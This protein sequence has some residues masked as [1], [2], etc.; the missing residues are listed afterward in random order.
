MLTA[1]E[2]PSTQ[3]AGGVNLPKEWSG[4]IWFLV[5]MGVWVFLM[6]VLP[7]FGIST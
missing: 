4:M 2:N 5:A 6:V 3:R 1:L 7:R